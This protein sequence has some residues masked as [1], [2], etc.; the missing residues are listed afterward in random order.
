MHNEFL[1]ATPFYENRLDVLAVRRVVG[2]L[3]Q[4]NIKPVAQKPILYR[5]EIYIYIFYV[6][7]CVSVRE[8]I[9]I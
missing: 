7:V 4:I 1:M 9:Q 6:H 5:T 2:S 8:Y 3:C